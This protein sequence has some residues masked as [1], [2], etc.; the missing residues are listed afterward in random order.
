MKTKLLTLMAIGAALTGC[1]APTTNPL[2]AATFGQDATL[3]TTGYNVEASTT[4]KPFYRQLNAKFDLQDADAL[5][6]VLNGQPVFYN[7]A[8]K[9]NFHLRGVDKLQRDGSFLT[10]GSLTFQDKTRKLSFQGN[11]THKEVYLT[12]TMLYVHM[13]GTLRDGNHFSVDINSIDP[14]NVTYDLAVTKPS[15][16]SKLYEYNGPA[17]KGHLNLSDH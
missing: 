8:T 11:V 16:G 4:L 3:Q 10:Q 14:Y 17:D 12:D 1:G 7:Q 9:V 5:A 13:E 6:Q 2:A 15:D